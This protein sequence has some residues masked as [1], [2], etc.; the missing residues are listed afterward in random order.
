MEHK[1]NKLPLILCGL[2]VGLINGFIGGGGGV[3]VVSLLSAV[4]N[5]TD[6]QSHATAIFVIF[7]I[8]LASAVIYIINGHLEL[9]PTVYITIGVVIGGI[10]GAAWLSNMSGKA[11]E[12]VFAVV[13]LIAGIR[14]V[15]SPVIGDINLIN[16]EDKFFSISTLYIF[17]CGISSGVLGGMG[18]GGGMFLIPLLSFTNLTQQVAQAINLISFIPMAFAAL[19]IHFKNKLVITKNM[20][21][22]IIP[23]LIL[24]V[25][26]A[27]IA[28]I[29]P[30]KLLRFCF[31]LIM[32]LLGS[33]QMYHIMKVAEKEKADKRKINRPSVNI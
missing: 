26:G 15:I 16:V 30:D 17:A 33:L 14:M 13:V 29:V 20:T 32:I 22:L 5:L 1:L 8:T 31:G 7:P 9:M 27:F 24:S 25:A 18:M 19:I 4:I 23:A 28:N 21:Y 2:G 6:R 12:I 10:I 3:I 11:I